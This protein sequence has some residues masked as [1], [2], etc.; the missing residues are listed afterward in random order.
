VLPRAHP[1]VSPLCVALS[2]SVVAALVTSSCSGAQSKDCDPTTIVVNGKCF[3][4]KDKACD[5][6]RCVPPDECVEVDSSPPSVECHK[7]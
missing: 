3:W 7:G 2:L 4:D 5:E 6:L 1:A